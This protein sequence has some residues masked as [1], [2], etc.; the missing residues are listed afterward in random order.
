MRKKREF[1][2][3]AH[4]MF[5][6]ARR[7]GE[8][9][10]KMKHGLGACLLVCL[11]WA[12]CGVGKT[13]PRGAEDVHIPE[14]PA[15]RTEDGD[16]QNALCGY[17]SADDGK[18]YLSDLKLHPL[19]EGFLRGERRVSNVLPGIEA[20]S[21]GIYDDRDFYGE[22]Y[23]DREFALV[24]VNHDGDLE[25][26]FRMGSSPSDILYL[27]GV[28]EDELV[29]FDIF[30][31]HTTHIAFD[32]YDNGIATWGQNY[33][34]EEEVYYAYGEDGGAR[35]LIHFMKEDDSDSGKY[36]DYYFENGEE[37]SKRDIQSDEEYESLS[38]PFRGG[39][40]RWFDCGDFAD[41]PQ[42]WNEE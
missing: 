8:S 32:L 29:C 41:I 25:L 4:G 20:D 23:A 24:D 22:I 1:R 34:G 26:I 21:L 38:G 37:D 39:E 3:E 33:D 31:T 14:E 30:E 12:A 28:G 7:F 40:P 6:Q 10:A 27:L 18:I 9:G 36:Y 42:W 35:E 2:N 5:G 17:P 15:W 11:F 16:L 19:Y 13:A